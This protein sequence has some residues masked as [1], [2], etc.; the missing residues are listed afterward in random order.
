MDGVNASHS[1]H[2]KGVVGDCLMANRYNSDPRWR[3]T[4]PVCHCN[5]ER[6]CDR[7]LSQA[8]YQ[9]LRCLPGSVGYR[10]DFS[11]CR[12]IKSSKNRYCIERV[13]PDSTYRLSK[14]YRFFRSSASYRTRFISSLPDS[15]S[16]FPF[17]SIP[18]IVVSA[19]IASSLS[20]VT[21]IRGHIAG[22]SPPSPRRFSP[23]LFIV[24]VDCN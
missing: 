22:N 6:P 9:M 7:V 8:R 24:R 5:L 19:L 18:S 23:R 15:F 21:Q 1:R 4:P 11:I 3:I 17:F 20:F 2:R 14:F 12:N 10:I 16:L 13:F